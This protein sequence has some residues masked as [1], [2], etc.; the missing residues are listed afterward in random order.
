MIEKLMKGSR[1]Y[2]KCLL[3]K[4]YLILPL[5]IFCS[6]GFVMGESFAMEEKEIYKIFYIPF[7]VE[8]Y[9]PITPGSIE[10]N[11]HYTF[12]KSSKEIDRVF[13]YS[14]QCKSIS[15]LRSDFKTTRVKK[16]NGVRSCLA[17]SLVAKSL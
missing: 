16:N 2:L 14:K 12:E 1:I 13:I 15:L 4:K 10:K 6:L 5:Y 7:D 17:D 11:A 8:T 3:V 9:I